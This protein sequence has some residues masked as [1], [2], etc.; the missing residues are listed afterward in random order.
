MTYLRNMH[1][2]WPLERFLSGWMAEAAE[3]V[4]NCIQCGECEGK[5]PYRLPIREMIQENIAFY[6]KVAS[7]NQISW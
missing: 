3:S 7:G 1:R 6:E 4:R 5:C 2:L